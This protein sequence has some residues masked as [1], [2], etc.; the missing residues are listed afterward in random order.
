MTIL[1][2]IR[3]ETPPHLH[4]FIA[5]EADLERDLQF[6]ALSRLCLANA[7]EEEF[8]RDISDATHEAWRTVGDVCATVD[9][10]E[11]E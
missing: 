1:A 11:V 4:A 3:A 5:P 8:G 9:E 2:L 10:M 7:I 6:D